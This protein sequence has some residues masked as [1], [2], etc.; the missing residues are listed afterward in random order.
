IL[1]MSFPEIIEQVAEQVLRVCRVC[2]GMAI[3]ENSEDRT[4]LVEAVRPED[5][6][7]REPELLSQA[8]DWLPRLPFADVDLLIVD[9]IG[10]N[11][12]GVGMDANVIGRKFND[13]AATAQDSVRC[14]RI[15]VRGL[16]PET[17]G[18]GTG[19]G[20]AEFT[21]R[22]V[23]EQIDP[24][25]TRVNCITGNHPEAAMIPIT[26]ETDREAVEAALTTIGMIAPQNARVIQI[27][28]TLH[29][30][31]VRVSEAYFED[32]RGSNRLQLDGQPYEFPLDAAGWLSDVEQ[33]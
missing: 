20:L 11:I 15:F 12:S 9:R 28:N 25:V 8:N 10:K 27:S 14:R 31:R 6:G 33:H 22:R 21:T 19:I 26:F 24:I 17:Y 23:V 2:G 30:S 29:L 18:N 7:R 5:F 13:H 3:L 32:V 4:A 1:T 16:T